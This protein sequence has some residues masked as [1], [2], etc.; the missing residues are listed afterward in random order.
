M[1]ADEKTT[2][3]QPEQTAGTG[4]APAAQPQQEAPKQQAAPQQTQQEAP[5]QE[6]SGESGRGIGLHR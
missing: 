1:M 6:S 4:A 5:K 2:Q 3:A